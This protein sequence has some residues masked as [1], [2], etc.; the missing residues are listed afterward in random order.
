[1]S[2]QKLATVA[3]IA[4][5]TFDFV[6]IGQYEHHSSITA[7]LALAAR[8]SEDPSVSVAVLEAGKAHFNDELVL[9]VQGWMRQFMNPE[10]DWRFFTLPQVH[11]NGKPTLWSRGK[12][13]GGS[14]GMNFLMWTRPQR[15]DIDA[16]EALGNSGWNWERFYEYSKKTERFVSPQKA[17]VEDLY[18]KDAVGTNGPLPISFARTVSNAEQPFRKSLEELGVNISNDALSGDTLG[19]WKP[20]SI[21]DPATDTRSYSTTGY[22]LPALD[23]PNLRVLTEAYVTRI[24]TETTDDGT[25][26]ARALEFEHGGKTHSVCVGKEAILSAGAIKSPQILELSGIGDRALLERLEIPVKLDLPAVGTNVQ[27]HGCHNAT[28][29]LM[30]DGKN[31][32]T[33]DLLRDPDFRAKLVESSPDYAEPLGLAFTGLNFLPIQKL[34]SPARA[35]EIISNI[36]TRVARGRADGS[37]PPGLQAQYE[38]QMAMLKDPA[39]PDV[40]IMVTPFSFKPGEPAKKPIVAILSAVCRPFSRGTIH[41]ASTDPKEP[42]AIDPQYFAESADLDILVEAWKFARKVAHTGAFKE[43]MVAEVSP[44]PGVQT[45]EQ[46]REHVKNNFVTVWHTCGSLSMLP[47]DKG[48]VVDPKLKVYGTQNIRVVDLSILPLQL[49]T[50][51]QSVVYAIAEQAA[52]I[53]KKDHDML[54]K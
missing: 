42:P 7:G 9:G 48:G 52:D 47:K 46:I 54:L 44:G 12:G 18:S 29:Y 8:L 45:D 53:I 28:A 27:E 4:D 31:I 3:D 50:H 40:E 26:V 19:A 20:V 35:T 49:T 14:S 16:I 30:Q 39:V 43:L 38:Q 36:E 1:M 10:Y 11:A 25:V 23:R 6:I 22:L 21:I 32:I 15:Q 33:S 5:R 13:L 24:I 41:A 51:T 34:T 2:E 17:T 37:I